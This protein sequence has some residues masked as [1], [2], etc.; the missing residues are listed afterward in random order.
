[1]GPA[2]RQRVHGAAGSGGP[3]GRNEAESARSSQPGRQPSMS[4]QRLRSRHAGS[5]D[6]VILPLA[7]ACAKCSRGPRSDTYLEYSKY[8]GCEDPACAYSW[9]HRVPQ[10][11]QG[12]GRIANLE[13]AGAG[14]NQRGGAT[15]G[16]WWAIGHRLAKA[17]ERIFEASVAF[18]L[19]PKPLKIRKIRTYNDI[20][21][22]STIEVSTIRYSRL[23]KY[24]LCT[25]VL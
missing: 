4:S 9:P 7:P 25:L 16:G 23:I 12:R 6:L 8:H 20:H 22:C 14:S 5:T 11:P 10:R 19:N 2:T 18:F 21:V 17:F 13:V 1:M 24:S 3:G 15:G